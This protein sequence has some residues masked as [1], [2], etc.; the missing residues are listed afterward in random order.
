MYDFRASHFFCF[1][2]PRCTKGIVVFLIA[3][4]CWSNEVLSCCQLVTDPTGMDLN[5]FLAPL[6]KV[7]AK[8]L[9]F[10]NCE[11][12]CSSMRSLKWL[13]WSWGSDFPSYALIARSLNSSDSF[14]SRTSWLKGDPV[15][16]AINSMLFSFMVAMA[17]HK[18]STGIPP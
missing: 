12:R 5:H 13:R 6:V 14:A 18:S 2:F 17:R 8:T 10:A 1:T 7:I 3:W 16:V 4:K 9:H 15:V 11:T